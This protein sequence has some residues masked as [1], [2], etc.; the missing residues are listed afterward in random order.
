MS[1]NSS[2][3][4]MA[5]GIWKL[6]RRTVTTSANC[7]KR[8]PKT[9][10]WKRKN[11]LSV[12]LAM[13]VRH[14]PTAINRPN[15][16]HPVVA[17]PHLRLQSLLKMCLWGITGELPGFSHCA[18]TIQYD[19]HLSPFSLSTKNLSCFVCS[20]C[21]TLLLFSNVFVQRLLELK[22]FFDDR[23]PG[24]ELVVLLIARALR[25]LLPAPWRTTV[26]LLIPL[27]YLEFLFWSSPMNR[28]SLC[29]SFA[30]ISMLFA[31]ETCHL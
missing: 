22:E 17:N 9:W 8:L 1:L 2:P 4:R 15:Q 6:L 24:H 21:Q 26:C 12:S 20:S 5:C 3:T 13:L 31:Q 25:H 19:L 7:F 16:W 27:V 23:N 30:V 14:C 28:L 11:Q 29:F 10:R 18:I